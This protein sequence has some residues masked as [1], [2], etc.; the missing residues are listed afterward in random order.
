MNPIENMWD[1][2]S[3]AIHNRISSPQ[4]AEELVAAAVEEFNN[5]PQETIHRL[6]VSMHTHVNMVLR[7]R[8]GH[9]DY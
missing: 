2:V 6:I 4:N 1:F 7:N 8:G 9:T 5:I 3:R